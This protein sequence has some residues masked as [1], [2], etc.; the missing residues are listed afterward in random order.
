[1]VPGIDA[2]RTTFRQLPL[3]RNLLKC[4]N[5]RYLPTPT[6]GLDSALG[7]CSVI[8]P[9]SDASGPQLVH[10]A[11]DALI[12]GAGVGFDIHG[13]IEP[14][15]QQVPDFA[16]RSSRVR[17]LFQGS[18]E[19]AVTDRDQDRVFLIGVMAMGCGGPIRPARP[20]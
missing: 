15:G 20:W 1:M 14:A 18:E 7:S 4:W 13:L 10:H 9:G 3:P 16:G 17:G 12:L 19:C 6:Q 5:F 8:K 11:F 2:G